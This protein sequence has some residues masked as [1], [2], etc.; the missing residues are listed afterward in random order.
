MDFAALKTA[1]QDYCQNSESTFVT[2]IP[3]FIIAA[4]D[5]IFSAVNLPAYWKQDDLVTLVA[6]TPEYAVE[7]GVINIESV[8]VSETATSVVAQASGVEFG[9]VRYLILKDYDFMLEAYPG[10]SGAG[11]VSTRGIP[12][13]YAVSSASTSNSNPTMTI[14]LGPAPDVVYPLTVTYLGKIAA[15][16]ITGGDGGVATPTKETWLSATFPD[17][18]MWG[19]VVEAYTFM[20]GEP[21]MMQV[22]EKRFLDSMTLVKYTVE[23]ES[24]SDAYRPNNTPTAQVQQG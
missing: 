17:C 19:S 18:L 14:R 3:D 8:R 5:K 24:A 16:S 7:E 15:D 23:T 2:H 21:D 1:I 20:K 13:Y 10:T 12:K 4:E 6:G 9:P 22:Y 11:G